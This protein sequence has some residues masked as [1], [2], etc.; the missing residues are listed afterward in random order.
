MPRKAISWFMS[1]FKSYRNYVQTDVS[2]YDE[3]I[4]NRYLFIFSLLLYIGAMSCVHRAILC[5]RQ[6][7]LDWNESI[8]LS[9]KLKMNIDIHAFVRFAR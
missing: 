6:T 7:I 3:S 5:D 4:A 1:P 8:C 2:T 9:L